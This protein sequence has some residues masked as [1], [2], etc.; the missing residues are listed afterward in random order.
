MD[1]ARTA[2]RLG[3]QNVYNVYRRTTEQMP[4]EEFEIKSAEEEGV[5]FKT[6][7]NPIEIFEKDGRVNAMELQ[8]M[9]LGEKDASGRRRPVAVEGKTEMLNVDTI[10]LAI[11]QA[12]DSELFGE[13]EKTKRNA[14]AYD[15][16]SFMTSMEGV[17]V[18]G[19]CGND[20]ISI[21]IEAIADAKK[22]TPPGAHRWPGPAHRA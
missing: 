1:A 15:E 2:V 22:V 19:D 14:I 16:K 20:K 9:E 6:L 7:R 13:V 17:F 5:I 18:G 10:I 3:A 8:V 21:A 4:A 12:V 11:G